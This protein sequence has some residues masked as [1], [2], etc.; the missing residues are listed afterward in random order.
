[1]N[2]KSINLIAI[3]VSL[4][5]IYLAK[6]LINPILM[7]LFITIIMIKP[8]EF[9]I[10]RKIPQGVA[11]SI[12]IAALLGGYFGLL[13]LIGSSI[14]MF[15]E[16][17]PEYAESL[18]EQT[19]LLVSFLE[20]KGI[21]MK[22]SSEAMDLSK[23]MDY[24]ANLASELGDTLSNEFTFLLLTIFLLAE[25]DVFNQKIESI[26]I[27]TNQSLKYL[28]VIGD[29]IRDYLSIK[30]MTSLL[31]GALV[32]VGLAIIGVDYPILWGLVAFLLN[33]IPNIGSILAAIPAIIMAFV[34]MGWD[35]VLWTGLLYLIVNIVIGN[36]IEPRIMGKGL[37]LSTF[38]VFVALVFWG[39]ILGPVGMFLSVPI[40]MA[41]KIILEQR[42]STKTI[43]LFL[44]NIEDVNSKKSNSPITNNIS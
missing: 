22:G 33:Y 20:G 42:E 29:S 13:T 21:S 34:Q 2:N 12:I 10:A 39:F 18:R 1:M 17:A 41:I 30:T 7:A 32:A 28:R 44:G 6:N 37:G 19:G 8:L 27:K 14:S 38:V 24:T 4:I 5:V 31:T 35:G 15:I 36:V 11:V 26:P 25:V 9:L 23:I 43:A 16:K 40:T 3:L